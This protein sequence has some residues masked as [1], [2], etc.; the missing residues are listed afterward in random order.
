[1]TQKIDGFISLDG[2]KTVKATI[3]YNQFDGETYAPAVLWD[4]V[5]KIATSANNEIAR[6]NGII[7][8]IKLSIGNS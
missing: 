1:M 2:I 4:D 3:A 5:V 6:L 7:E 8:G